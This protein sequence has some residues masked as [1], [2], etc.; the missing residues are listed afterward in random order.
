MLNRCTSQ[1]NSVATSTTKTGNQDRPPTDAAAHSLLSAHVDTSDS[2][3]LCPWG[4]QAVTP[5][6]AELVAGRQ[7]GRHTKN[8]YARDEE[9]HSRISTAEQNSVEQKQGRPKQ[10]GAM[11]A[12]LLPTE[13]EDGK[14]KPMEP[15]HS[16]S[17]LN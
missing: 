12:N 1:V 10:D 16:E 15:T 3:S 9:G 7:T 5:G 13:G 4:E 2:K 14:I 6:N 17:R 11:L 8:T